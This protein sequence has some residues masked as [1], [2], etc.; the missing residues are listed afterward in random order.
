[1]TTT[2]RSC[3]PQGGPRKLFQ[4][5]FAN[6]CQPFLRSTGW[7][8]NLFEKRFANDCQPFLRSTE[9]PA[10]IKF[11]I[12]TASRTCGSTEWSIKLHLK[13]RRPKQIDRLLGC[14]LAPTICLSRDHLG[15]SPRTHFD[16]EVRL[17]RSESLAAFKSNATSNQNMH[18]PAHSLQTAERSVVSNAPS[19]M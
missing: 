1:M 7:P 10:K 18:P 4:R 17:R 11:E 19:R 15:E 9:W 16:T 8:T 13:T 3:D 2:S 14:A 5:R 12:T 6:D